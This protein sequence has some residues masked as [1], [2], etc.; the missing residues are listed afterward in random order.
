[1][2]F[3]YPEA[4]PLE[5]LR[6]YDSLVMNA[7]RWKLAH[8]YHSHRQSIVYQSL[9]QPGIVYGLG[10]TVLQEPPKESS[11][12]FQN[13]DRQRQEV[14]WI[15]IQPGVA[16]DHQGNPI[17]VDEKTDRSYRIAFDVFENRTRTIYIVVRYVDPEELQYSDQTTTIQDRFRFEQ[18][19]D[20]PEFGE[21][22][23]CRIELGSNRVVLKLPDDLFK[24]GTNEIDVR[25]RLQAQ[26]RAQAMLRIG[27]VQP[28]QPEIS[29]AIAALTRSLAAIFPTLQCQTHS[30]AV[31]SESLSNYDVL[32]VEPELLKLGNRESDEYLQECGGVYLSIVSDASSA[33]SEL[34]SWQDHQHFVRLQ[35][36]LF[37]KLPESFGLWLAPQGD[38][39]VITRSLIKAWLGENLTRQ[40]I[41]TAHEI[42]INILHFIWQRRRLF[43]SLQSRSSEGGFR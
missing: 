27:T 1:M 20:P 36:F 9:Y 40:D 37:T 24:P 10:I 29:A 19:T 32:Y 16:I 28:W 8:H 31:A 26:F 17:V 39:I 6:I 34:V 15:E 38:R 23:L 21:I 12:T 35:P 43:Q 41:R 11:L 18:R 42:G 5:R 7:D 3:P 2:Q 30:S 22:E 33:P 4:N 25:Y 13:R 14:R